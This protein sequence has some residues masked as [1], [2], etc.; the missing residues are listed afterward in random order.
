MGRVWPQFEAMST[1]PTI[2]TAAVLVIGNEILSGRTQDANT[3]WLAG[4]LTALGIRLMEA[5]V[6]ADVEADIIAAVTALSQRWDYVFTTG[7]IG[8]THDDI[9]SAAIAKAFGLGFGPDPRAVAI[10]HG[11]YKPEDRTPARMKMA[12]VPVGADL[13]ENPVSKAPGFRV[14]N[15]FVMAGVPSIMKAMFDGVAGGL[16]GGTPVLA[17]TVAC[18]L[19]EG[20][21]AADLGRLQ[22]QHPDVDIGSYPWFRNGQHGTSLVARGTDPAELDQIVQGLTALIEAHGGVATIETLS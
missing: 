1:A 21:I 5:R 8:P 9:T 7:G 2:V 11:H 22:D 6:V 10:L 16:T 14:Q 18:T 3:H 15:V 12:E 17:R 20:L 4:R 19:G 13:I